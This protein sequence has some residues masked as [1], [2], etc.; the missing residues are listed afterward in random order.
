MHDKCVYTLRNIETGEVTI[1]VCY[2]DDVLFI[3]NSPTVIESAIDYL[4][5]QFTRLTNMGDVTRY[6]G[7]D[8]KRDLD[9]NTI[10]LSQKP[11]NIAKFIK[12]RVKPTSSVKHIPLPETV[13]YSKKGDSTLPPILD[14]VGTL[15]YLADRTRPDLLTAVGSI[16]SAASNPTVDHVRGVDLLLE[17]GEA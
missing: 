12:D 15:R 3:G 14:S 8:I 5:T 17:I 1:I 10:E 7:V 16:G 2:V 4:V 11:Y 9:K 13:D 6:L